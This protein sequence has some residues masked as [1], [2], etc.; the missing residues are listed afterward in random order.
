MIFTSKP[1]AVRVADGFMQNIITSSG[2]YK[3]KIKLAKYVVANNGTSGIRFLFE[4]EEDGKTALFTLFT[5]KENGKTTKA[6]YLL[7]SIMIILDIRQLLPVTLTIEEFDKRRNKS[8]GV[9]RPC[10]PVLHDKEIIIEIGARKTYVKDR[11]PTINYSLLNVFDYN[12]QQSAEEIIK[13]IPAIA[14]IPK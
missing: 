11:Y 10:Y 5:H 14:F 1:D 6:F 3:G 9:E 4:N 2:I 12:T 13:N 7:N 8:V